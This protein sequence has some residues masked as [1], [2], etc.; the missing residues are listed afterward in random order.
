MDWTLFSEYIGKLAKAIKNN[1]RDNINYFLFLSMSL[2]FEILHNYN[3]NID[4][5]WKQWKS[6]ALHKI[7]ID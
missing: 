3:I 1:D 4:I 7:Y 5:A 2:L 6:K